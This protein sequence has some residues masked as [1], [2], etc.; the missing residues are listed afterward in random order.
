VS[1]RLATQIVIDEIPDGVAWRLVG[2]VGEYSEG[3]APGGDV[4][5]A[6]DLLP[7]DSVFAPGSY[8]WVVPGGSGVGA[9]EQVS[10][11]DTR[12][13]GNVAVV[14]TLEFEGGEEASGPVTIPFVNDM[15]LQTADGQYA[16]DLE[17]LAGSLDVTLPTQSATFQ[18]PG[19]PRPVVRYDVLGDVVSAFVLRVPFAQTAEFR[20]VIASGAPVV[21][22]FG[23]D[24]YD[25]D[26]VG[27]VA[28]TSVQGDPYP[29]ALQRWWTLGYVLIDDPYADVR[30]GAF[31]WDAFD[32]AF[33][34][35]PWAPDFDEAFAGLDW[36][37]FD[38]ADFSSL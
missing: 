30:L 11:V 37:A 31:S 17:L 8:S 19:R 6:D 20:R 26:P 36:D 4:L 32:E 1:G 22:R 18:V 15:V 5:P 24:S 2:H 14:Y 29:T 21:Y 13:P 3:L 23:A 33:V 12:A 34:G 16:I 27:V 38:T 28:L 25:L 35:R 10:L 9:G 7:M